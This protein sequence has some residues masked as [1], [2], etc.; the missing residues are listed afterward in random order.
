[1]REEPTEWTELVTAAHRAHADCA[2]VP[3]PQS[4]AALQAAIVR[5]RQLDFR[6]LVATLEA[7][8]AARASPHPAPS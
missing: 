4:T 1:M 6:T 3:G 8:T 5:A 2:T 7:A